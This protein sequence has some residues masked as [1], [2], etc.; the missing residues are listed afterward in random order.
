MVDRQHTEVVKRALVRDIPDSFASALCAAAP[1]SPIDVALARAQHAA[2]VDALA[3]CGVRV[4]RLPADDAHP[5]CCFV[6]DT[7]V[8][9]D[10]VALITQPGHPSRR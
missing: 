6:E 4:Q 1:A 2:Y 3:A 9:I 5:D 8:I 7:A 10:G